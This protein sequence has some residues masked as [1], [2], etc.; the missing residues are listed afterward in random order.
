MQL[1]VLKTHAWNKQR[2]ILGNRK[3]S[4]CVSKLSASEILWLVLLKPL[5]PV[6][7]TS[8]LRSEVLFSFINERKNCKRE[9]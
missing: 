8:V 7:I 1:P 4:T 3:K 9:R 6:T 2:N 5:F